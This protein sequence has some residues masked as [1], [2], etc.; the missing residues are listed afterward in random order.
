MDQ[1][2]ITDLLG[3]QPI[4]N[5]AESI[6]E[7]FLTAISI[8]C[9]PAFEELGYLAKDQIRRWRLMNILKML[10]KANGKLEY[11]DGELQI[12]A[13][14]KVTLA[15]MENASLEEKDE[16]QELWAGLFASSCTDSGED[17]QN[18]IF[19]DLLKQLTVVQSR[20]LKYACEHSIKVLYP[21]GFVMS[22]ELK[23]DL[24]KLH[25]ITGINDIYRLDRDMDHLSSIKLIHGLVAGFVAN[26]EV[27]EA[28]ITPSPLALNLYVRCLGSS[29]TIRE[30]WKESL[31][32]EEEMKERKL[33]TAPI[34]IS[35]TE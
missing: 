16:V 32:S 34:F 24:Q 18:I 10:Q 29:K 6:T 20:I 17:D 33:H 4:A 30:Y 5:A 22:T 31:I 27:V 8:V 12:K 7:K 19:V 11:T 2:A 21:T 14:P 15:I 25:E 3:L 23:V 35:A 13:N 1:K 28:V 9:K 26:T